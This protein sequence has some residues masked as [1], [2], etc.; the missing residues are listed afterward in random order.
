[1]AQELGRVVFTRDRYARSWSLGDRK[2]PISKTP[3]LMQLAGDPEMESFLSPFSSKTDTKIPSTLSISSKVALSP[4]DFSENGPNFESFIGHVLPPSLEE[5][6]AGE[7]AGSG[8]L[9][10][11]SWQRLS[12]DKELLDSNL[13]PS[14]IVLVDSVQLAS[15]PGKLVKAIHVLKNKFP[16]SLLWTPGIGGPDNAAVLNWFGVDIFDLSRSRM[17]NSAGVILSE[18]G[19]RMPDESMNESATMD[20]QIQHWK[21]SIGSIKSNLKNGTLRALVDKQS[22]NSPHLV[23]HLRA[24]DKICSN[25]I[26]LLS[27]HVDNEKVLDCS[28]PNTLND[29]VVK[30]WCE[31]IS[32]QYIAPKGLDNVLILLPCSARKPYRLSK[33]HGRFIRAINSNSCHEVM[34]TSPLGLVPRDLEEIWPA[35]HYDIPVTGD[36]T[37]DELIR[38]Q[39]MLDSLLARHNYNLVINHSGMKLE[40]GKVELKETRIGLSAGSSEALENLSEAVKEGI[41]IHSVANRR[42][43]HSLMDTFASVS[44]KQ[45]N[46]D[47][48]LEGISIRGKPPFWRLEKDNV[49]VAIWSIDRRGFSFSKSAIEILHKNNSLSKVSI[50]SGPKLK[51][52]IFYSNIASYDS[53]IKAGNDI[54]VYQDDLPV[55]LARAVAPAWEWPTTGGRLAK[56]HQ[57]L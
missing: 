4:P 21:Q 2:K 8:Q 22:L 10:P 30:E 23:E 24:H 29:P 39:T 47:K 1:M 36:W 43:N 27:S 42:N 54:L 35:S 38:T 11:V 14:I 25:Q 31:F 55:G 50:K 18:N 9:L 12:H 28:S 26:G 49:Q 19:P 56:T 46:N 51:G 53:D 57:R 6:N 16:G 5:A 20:V 44:R 17:C 32:N 34:V 41:Q 33:S 48:W 45:L 7:S 52:D 15:Q 40:T 37:N 13:N 3:V